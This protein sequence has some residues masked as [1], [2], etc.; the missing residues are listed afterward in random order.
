MPDPV[1]ADS[2]TTDSARTPDGEPAGPPGAD[3]GADPGVAH[4]KPRGLGWRGLGWHSAW[5]IGRRIAGHTARRVAT[6]PPV[7][8]ALALLAVALIVNRNRLGI[9][10]AG[11]RLLPAEGLAQTWWRYVSGWQAIAGGTAVPAPAALAV[12]GVVGTALVPFGGVPSAVAVLLLGS[13]PLA[14]LSAYL[15]TRR[16]PASR[17]TRAAV[18]AGYAMLPV[19]TSAVASG[20]LDVAVAHVL[21]PIVFAAATGVVL[22]GS[23][24]WLAAAAGAAVGLAVL[25]A[26]SP[27]AYL[28]VLACALGG[29]VLAPRHPPAAGG[30]IR[31]AAALFVIVLVPPLL[32]LPWSIELLR[33]PGLVLRGLGVPGSDAGASGPGASIVELMALHPGGEG[34]APFVG[35]AVP[36][37][38]VAAMAMRPGRAALPGLG[39]ALAGGVTVAALAMSSGV[40]QGHGAPLVAVGWGLLLAFASACRPGAARP[41]V[42]RALAGTAAAV[43]AALAVGALATGHAG[44]LRDDGGTRLTPELA[45]ELAD[46][47]R[48]VLVLAHDRNSAR[49]VAGRMPALGDDDVTPMPSAEALIRRLDDDLRSDQPDVATAAV[50]MAA[51]RGV[52]FVVAP[53]ELTGARLLRV[54]GDMVAP[55]PPT[56]DGR[57]VVRLRPTAGTA[58]LLA[59]EPAARAVSGDAPADDPAP[60]GVVPVAAGAPELAVRV[61]D[62]PAGR[63]LV[64][65]AAVQPGWRASVAGQPAPIATAWGGLVAVPVPAGAADVRISYSSTGHAVLLLAQAAAALFTLLI[66][67]PGRGRRR[68]SGREAEGGY[69]SPSIAPGSSPR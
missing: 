23:R 58:V 69:P 7:V 52:I 37:A 16:L 22:R 1:T 68:T 66:A 47:G 12:L 26:F 45:R 41:A 65:T 15:A 36:L 18:A 4:V 59:P 50:A 32:L 53:D 3:P 8:L 25:G 67:I 11:G 17:W 24:S 51:T 61:S 40:P 6:S 30:A 2:V 63:L 39:L 33:H 14:G 55:V 10:L 56:S 46:T 57:P 34:A 38:V 60:P 64:L 5:H 54:G 13:L 19:G 44:Q 42:D 27:L 43:A 48:S 35:F 49:Q 28:V 21:L 31:R 29:Y 20:R 62:G 9:D